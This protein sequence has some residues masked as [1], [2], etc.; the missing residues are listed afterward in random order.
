MSIEQYFAEIDGN[1]IVINIHVVT[2][3]FLDDNPDRYPGMYVETFVD[4][5]GKTYAGIGYTYDRAN[6]DFISPTYALQPLIE[7]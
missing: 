7:E 4:V 1:D 2:Q 5:I 6:D 3:Q